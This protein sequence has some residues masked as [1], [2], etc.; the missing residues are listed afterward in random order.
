M[1]PEAQEIQR[2]IQGP[3][4][5][6]RSRYETFTDYSGVE[7]CLAEQTPN[8]PQ[9]YNSGNLWVQ[10]PGWI[11]LFRERLD[12]RIIALDGRRHVDSN[13]RQWHGNSVGRFEGNTL[14]VE[15]TNFTDKQ[16]RGGVGST[17]P[18]GI[19]LGN[20]KLVEHFVPVSPTRMHYY[21][22]IEDPKTWVR[23]WT[24]MIPWEKDPT[25]TVFEYAC[26]EANIAIGNSLRGERELEREAIQK[27]PLPKEQTSAGLVGLTEADIR[28]KLGEPAGRDFNGARW[29]Y[30]TASGSLVLNLFFEK[31]Q[32]KIAQPNDLPLTDLRRR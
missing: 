12:T 22:T 5:P 6:G 2:S 30:E 14:I 15:T 13:I 16:N 25:Y 11:V 26:H 8:G 4:A 19:P 27:P 7:R 29:T 28:A 21:A 32:V 3:R 9:M 1:T 18:G 23:P 20:L 10:S 24:F 31:G 17:I